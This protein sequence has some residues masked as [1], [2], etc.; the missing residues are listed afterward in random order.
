MRRPAFIAAV[1]IPL[2]ILVLQGTA[3]ADSAGRLVRRGNESLERGDLDKAAE[4][5][6]LASVKLPESPVISFDL[7]N[8]A[9]LKGDY[10]AARGHYEEAALKARDLSLEARA[11]Y[12]I[13][14]CAFRQGQRQADSDLEKALDYFKQSVEYYSAA[15]EKEPGMPDAA[16][17]LEVARLM[18][19]DMLDAIKKQQE[20]MREQQ[21]KMRAVVDSLLAVM[22]RQ[23]AAVAGSL[24]LDDEKSRNEPGWEGKVKG[25]ADEQGSIEEA[26]GKVGEM[27]GDI[28][29]DGKPE[30]VK[31][32]LA[33][34]DSSAVFQESAIEDLRALRPG[35]A[36]G[37]QQGSLEQM[38]KALEKLTGGKGNDRNRQQGGQDQQEQDRQQQDQR[39]QAGQ[40]QQEKSG[41]E[42]QERGEKEKQKQDQQVR[43][44]TARNILDEEKK[45]RERR[46]RASGG[47]H[48]VDKDW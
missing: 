21:E 40:E 8:V 20:Q 11:L 12:N 34:L 44:A 3:Y 38:K 24:D 37:K 46:K 2:V 45:N 27:L 39:Q 16:H 14:N 19:K 4:Y 29:G 22:K 25:A 15:L 42:Q 48:K 32:A 7:G 43:S 5:Y 6:E 18:I 10:E 9:Y 31:G 35:D 33:N 36:V 28:F 47:Y 26:T 1:V 13:G 30:Q 23:D 41:Q 17:N